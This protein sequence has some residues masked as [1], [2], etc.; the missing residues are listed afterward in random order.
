MSVCAYLRASVCLHLCVGCAVQRSVRF[1]KS[2]RCLSLEPLHVPAGV[3]LPGQPGPR[4]VQTF[5]VPGHRGHSG[6]RS[7]EAF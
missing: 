5:S 2:P 6:H 1:G 3:Q 7:E 4:G